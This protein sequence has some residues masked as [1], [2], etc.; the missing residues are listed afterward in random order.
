MAKSVKQF[1]KACDTCQRCKGDAP[2]PNP[3]QALSVPRRPW[4]DLS[5]D[6]I[7]GLPVTENGNNAILTFVD[8]LTK[9]AH[10]VPTSSSVTAEGT[11]NL[12]L[13]NV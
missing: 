11:A 4:E 8:R 9:Y 3:L 6:F 5:M 7:T 12:Y 1:V 13:R 2:R 10:F